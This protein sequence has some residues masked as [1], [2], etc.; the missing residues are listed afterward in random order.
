MAEASRE[1]ASPWRR[2][3][4]K[5]PPLWQRCHWKAPP[6]WQRRHWKAPRPVTA[7]RNLRG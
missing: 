5:A 7:Y 2:R 1:G 4:G 6:P 3:A